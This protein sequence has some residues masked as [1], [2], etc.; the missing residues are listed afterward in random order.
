MHKKRMTAPRRKTRA[1]MCA[2]APWC[3]HA[4]GD[5][6]GGRLEYVKRKMGEGKPKEVVTPRSKR[7]N[8]YAFPENVKVVPL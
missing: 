5:L 8:L 1:C 7:E 6:I 3:V 4:R 2:C